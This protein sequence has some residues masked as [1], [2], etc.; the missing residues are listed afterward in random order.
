VLIDDPG[1]NQLTGS[2]LGA[3]IE[4][5][6]ILGPGLL[7]SVYVR[8]LKLELALRRLRFL[9][10]HVVPI[11]YKDISLPAHHRVDL[12]V[13]DRVI[14]EVKAV[15]S[16]L[17]VH[18]AQVLTYLKLTGCPAGLLINFNVGKLMD[19]VKRLVNPRG[20]LGTSA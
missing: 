16:L 15:D 7:E 14:V 13:E 11:I 12:V 17:G 1:L 6:R 20:S 18:Q 3:A 19:G 2:I 5:H 4:V 9:E 8:C 10:E